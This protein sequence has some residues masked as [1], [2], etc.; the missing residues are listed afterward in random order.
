[1]LI[2]AH[3]TVGLLIGT[4]VK[5]PVLSFFL[6]WLSHYV[7]DF[8]P[9]SDSGYFK[10]KGVNWLKNKKVLAWIFLDAILSVTLLLTLI[11]KRGFQLSLVSA[12]FGSLLPDIIDN[13][14]FWSK[15][16]RKFYPINWEYEHIHKYF[17]HT[18]TSKKLFLSLAIVSY[19]I[20]LG[21]IIYLL[22]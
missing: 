19:I 13:S 1:M 18:I 12:Y 6:A 11:L 10:V 3:S 22:K 5:N 20:N 8:I 17:H 15:S 9:H 21:A 2:L 14:P 4:V 7:L 16:L